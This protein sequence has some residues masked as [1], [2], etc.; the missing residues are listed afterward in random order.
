MTSATP[1]APPGREESR[2]ERLAKD[3]SPCH[4]K[5]DDLPC[6][7]CFCIQHNCSMSDLGLGAVAQWQALDLHEKHLRK[8]MQQRG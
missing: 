8:E 4:N 3:S 1:R 5:D 7:V 2:A 6:A